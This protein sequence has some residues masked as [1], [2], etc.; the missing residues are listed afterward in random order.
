MSKVDAWSRLGCTGAMPP[1]YPRPFVDSERQFLIL[2][3][4]WVQRPNPK[5]MK[6]LK[7]NRAKLRILSV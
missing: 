3:I 5:I 7:I 6:G 2:I 1:F 4:L